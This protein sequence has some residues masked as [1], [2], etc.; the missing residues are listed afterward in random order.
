M[1]GLTLKRIID[2]SG[3]NVNE[4]SRRTGIPAQTLYS[5]IR[6]D[7]MKIDFEV[8]LRLCEALDAPVERFYDG[9]GPELPKPEE[10]ALV[11]RWRRL[12][13]H[14][15]KLTELVM[16]AEL[17]RLDQPEEEQPEPEKIIPLYLSPAAAGFASPVPGEDFEEYSVPA[18]S[19]A[20]F[21]VRISGNSMEPYIADG[22]IVLVKRGETIRDGDVGLFFADFGMVCKQYCQDYAGNVYLFSLNR[23]RADADVSIPATSDTRLCCFGKVL[24][25]K[26]LPLPR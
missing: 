15:Q 21:A 25:D 1:I 14:G 19:R 20:D 24:M 10:W 9:R 22:S 13:A 18:A 5:L 2:E 12:D 26:T 7:S 23:K 16:N 11:S 8:L 6:R 3:T 17:S 4:L